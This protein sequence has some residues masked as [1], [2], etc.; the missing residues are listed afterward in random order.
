MVTVYN[1]SSVTDITVKVFETATSLAENTRYVL[2]TQFTI[3]KSQTIT[4]TTID[5]TSKLVHGIFN[6][7][8]VRFV[9][10]NDTVLGASD[11]FSATLRLREV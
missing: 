9:L 1:P 3:P 11:G 5:T 8:D 2:I 4:G 6:G 10:S 7:T